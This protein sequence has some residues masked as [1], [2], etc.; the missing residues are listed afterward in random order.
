[1]TARVVLARSIAALVPCVA[2]G[3]QALHRDPAHHFELRLP[4]DW[5]AV[6]AEQVRRLDAFLSAQLQHKNFRY[7]SA[8]SPSGD[9]A[10]TPYLVMQW[11]P[12]PMNALDADDLMLQVGVS[13]EALSRI[14]RRLRGVH[15][16]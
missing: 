7:V 12:G 10:Q 3:A 16:R 5:R 1:M 11:T 2:F 8:F 14:R 9:L 6:P 4:E 13:P 15:E